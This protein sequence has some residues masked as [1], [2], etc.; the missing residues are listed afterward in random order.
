MLIDTYTM[1]V[2]QSGT[3]EEYEKFYR[4]YGSIVRNSILIWKLLDETKDRLPNLFIE[5]TQNMRLHEKELVSKFLMLGIHYDSGKRKNY[6]KS[7][8]NTGTNE[9]KRYFNNNISKYIEYITNK[10]QF[11]NLYTA[12]E[13][14]IRAYLENGYKIKGFKQE[15]IVTK[16]LEKENDL[17]DHYECLCN[18]I[19][20]ENQFKKIW[21]YYTAL[22][23]LYSHSGGYIGQKF[24]DKINAVRKELS[25]Y[26]N[27]NDSIQIE[28]SLLNNDDNDLFNFLYCKADNKKKLFIISEVNLRFFRN[29]IVHI[30]EAIYTHKYP[31]INVKQQY[32]LEKN[33]FIFS[34]CCN[35]EESD[36]LQKKEQNI[37]QN[38]PCF[39]VSGYLCPE[40]KEMGLFLYKAK[41]KSQI[42]IS[43]LIY[44]KKNSSYMARNVFTCPF[45][46][47]FYFPEYMKD[48]KEN[49]GFNMLN[50]N[51]VEYE[52]LLDL[53][54][55]EADINFG[56]QFT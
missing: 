44:K 31:D 56:W 30:W 55:S 11:L 36:L 22:R 37:T 12:F 15:E 10:Q 18:I 49:N 35:K 4:M 40:C 39:N 45:C 29:F 50:L 26:I 32:V 3:L 51:E 28:L 25:D 54:E 42:D 47:S 33:K 38:N 21:I 48:L 34:L 20:S 53:F 52:E 46:R 41:F 23:N 24:L 16:I 13:E 6:D 14:S 9:I 27:E 17:L 2:P 1:I 8:A 7:I 5:M 19:F 43:E